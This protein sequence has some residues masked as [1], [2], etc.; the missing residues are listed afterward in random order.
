MNIISRRETGGLVV[1]SPLL[2]SFFTASYFDLDSRGAGLTAI[3]ISFLEFIFIT[4]KLFNPVPGFEPVG[5]RR[6]VTL[7]HVIHLIGERAGEKALAS[8]SAAGIHSSIDKARIS[9]VIFVTARRAGSK[10]N[11]KFP[12]ISFRMQSRSRTLYKYLA[13]M[14]WTL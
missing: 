5:M 1:S 13:S 12:Y 9:M 10:L 11:E 14:D 8:L 3:R 7:A 4:N 2:P 6:P